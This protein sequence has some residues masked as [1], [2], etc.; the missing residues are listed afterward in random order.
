MRL[1]SRQHQRINAG[2]SDRPGQDR[3]RAANGRPSVRSRPGLESLEDRALLSGV[4]FSSAVSYA[5]GVDVQDAVSVAEGDFNGD[6]KLDLAVA[7][8]DPSNSAGEVSVL[9][10]NGDGTFQTA[11]KFAVGSEPRSVAVADFNGDGKTDLAVANQESGTVSVLLGKGDGTFQSAQNFAVGDNESVAVA[12][13]NGD[14]KGDLV[15][16]NGVLLGNGDGTF[17]AERNFAG[18]GDTAA[19]ADFNGDGK[20]DVVLGRFSG[21]DSVLLGNGDGTFQ[22]ARNVTD[23]FGDAF[24]GDFVAIGDWNGDKKLDLAEISGG[25]VTVEVGNGD[26]TF[27]FT[28]V[29][30][31]QI[32]S[33]PV[34]VGDFNGD[35]KPDLALGGGGFSATNLAVVLGNGDGTFGTPQFPDG[36][37]FS[38]AVAVGDFNGDG[39][40][41]LASANVSGFAGSAGTVR[42][43]MNA[44]AATTAVSGPAS[45]SYGQSVTYT[46]TV[47]SGGG[48]VT[49]GTVTFLDGGQLPGLPLSPAISAALPLDAN[50]QAS[51]SIA[52]LN[53]YTHTITASYSGTPSGAGTTGFGP[54]VSSTTLTV[55]PLPLSVAA[56]NFSAI[57]GAPVSAVIATFI[58]PD[59]FGTAASYTATID[60]GD[61]STTSGIITGTG[62]LTVSG[63]AHAYAD[64]GTDAVSVQIS[65]NL[66]NTTTAT[67]NATANVTSLGQGV[68]HGLTGG[69]GFWHNKKGQAL[70]N[71]LNDGSNA[72]ALSTWL[73][74]SFPN[75]Y[76]AGAGANNLTGDT[77]AQ[78]AA[79]YTTQFALSGSNVEAEVLATALNVYATTQSLGGTT[80][81]AYGFTVSATGLGADSLSVGADGS[82]FGVANKTKLNVYELLK[83][84]DEQAVSGVLF[85]GDKKLRKQANDLFDALNNAGAIS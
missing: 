50:G 48:P 12:D 11:M 43:V 21:S 2:H 6:R 37:G 51:F 73:A 67:V 40:P 22:A 57:A 74:T 7:G 33:G 15:V 32:N 63:G 5:V 1:V 36:G 20:P 31:S 62:T 69:I 53:A 29:F 78:V 46:A 41:D 77:D 44:L 52:S 59:P 23:A 60:R 65:H 3:R 16:A 49:A 70:I 14:G 18:A 26:G 27:Q 4:S 10:G 83:S 38:P 17:Q 9:L 64:P 80:G 61:G 39:K 68:K 66:G 58:N 25:F 82:A 75:L 47:T 35:G 30:N 85:N 72:T 13:F 45:S 81:Q 24:Q 71:S 79:Y 84:V 8:T 55:A 54:G 34:V 42:V 56:I 76:G 19:V 28:Q